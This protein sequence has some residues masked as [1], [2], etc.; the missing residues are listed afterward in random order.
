[1][2]TIYQS[3]QNNYEVIEPIGEG[4]TAT[5]FKAICVENQ[6][7]VALK[8]FHSHLTI[9]ET[10]T[11]CVDEL[12]ALSTVTHTNIVSTIDAGLSGDNKFI[13]MELLNGADLEL[14]LPDCQFKAPHFLSFA[15]Q[16]LSALT[17]IHSH[18][19]Y[20][21]DIK[22]SNIMMSTDE[23]GNM[24]VKLVDFGSAR[25]KSSTHF[26]RDVGKRGLKGSI[27]YMSPEQI[28]KEAV[29]HRSDIYSLGCVFYRILTGK[30][31]FSGSSAVEVM[32][33]HIQGKYTPILELAPQW[34]QS[35]ATI[36]ELMI[37]TK[38][39]DRPSSITEILNMMLVM[40][41]AS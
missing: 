31:A 8:V 29:D 25:T 36:V 35:I 6:Q 18:G 11:E 39:D 20:H 24:L 30:I 34:P 26:D 3:P 15:Y 28:N 14:F 17:E 21:L 40:K 1:M 23:N 2:K 33:S 4:G 32:S 19:V 27:H 22:P 7:E 16:S 38:P 12:V 5:V 37:A 10:N 9:E 41:A 13:V